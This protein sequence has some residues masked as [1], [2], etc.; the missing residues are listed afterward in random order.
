MLATRYS[1]LATFLTLRPFAS[2][3]L[4]GKTSPL[5]LSWGFVP[6]RDL[7]FV[8]RIELRFAPFGV[9]SGRLTAVSNPE[10]PPGVCR[11]RLRQH[12]ER[13]VEDLR[14]RVFGCVT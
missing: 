9:I 4:V 3:R 13:N 10:K 14:R 1:V 8:L 11:R 5:F 7:I 6:L 2:L 12:L